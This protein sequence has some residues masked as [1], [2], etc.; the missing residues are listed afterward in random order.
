MVWGIVKDHGGFVEVSSGP[1][2]GTTFTLY[3]PT[4]REDARPSASPRPEGDP[5]PGRGETVL[6]VDDIAEQRTIAAGILNRL[7]Y[8][9]VSM[10]SGEAAVAYLAENTA[11]LVVLVMVMDPGMDG[12]ETYVRILDVRP[13]QRAIIASGY[14]ETDRVREARRLGAETYLKKPYTIE[15]LGRAVRRELDR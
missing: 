3:L 15:K 11:D 14:A 7:G 1:D 10:E 13:G 5:Q 6:G 2:P 12:L 8:R 4:V 9:A